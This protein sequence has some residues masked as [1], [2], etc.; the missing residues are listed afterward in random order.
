MW[1]SHD[2]AGRITGLVAV[3]A[4]TS[5]DVPAARM[6]VGMGSVIVAGIGNLLLTD[7]GVGVRVV[8]ALQARAEEFPEV[9]FLDLGAAG[10]ALLHVLAGRRKAVIVDCAFMGETP[11][12][13]RRFT[14]EE[15]RSVKRLT[16][17]SLHE[18]DLLQVLELARAL[19][20]APDEIVVLGIQPADVSPG[21]ELS[22][23][24]QAKLE[25]CVRRVVEEVHPTQLGT[26]E[27]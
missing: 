8:Q 2:A 3:S 22:S 1:N 19:G 13:I 20:Q 27:R 5:C 7:E 25:E 24:L 11:G 10:M 26:P 14:P 12:T 15:A 9:E 17:F 4:G 6:V 23:V 21:C 16:G 18:G